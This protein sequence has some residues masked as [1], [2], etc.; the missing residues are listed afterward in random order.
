[1]NLSDYG[2]VEGYS[3]GTYDPNGYVN[4]AEMATML[5]RALT[6]L[7]EDACVDDGVIYFDGDTIDRGDYSCS[8]D[9]GEIAMCTGDL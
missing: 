3:D 4:R 8:C 9:E 2:I 1:M 6:M 7:K 5:D